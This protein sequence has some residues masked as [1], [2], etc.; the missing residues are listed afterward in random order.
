MPCLHSCGSPVFFICKEMPACFQQDNPVE[1]GKTSQKTS[2]KQSKPLKK[3]VSISVN[4]DILCENNWKS[5]LK[6][7]K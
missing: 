3:P 2:Q 5:R 6:D 4:E 7:R 1:C